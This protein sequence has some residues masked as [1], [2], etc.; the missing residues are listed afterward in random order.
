MRN[1]CFRI[2][3]E[4]FLAQINIWYMTLRNNNPRGREVS[5]RKECAF[6]IQEKKQVAGSP[7]SIGSHY[8]CSRRLH[9]CGILNSFSLGGG[10]R[11][12]EISGLLLDSSRD[13]WRQTPGR[14]GQG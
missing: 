2:F 7:G 6:Q 1:V 10:A 8:D 4:Y 12:T 3:S 5:Y 11:V 14:S 9:V 13:K